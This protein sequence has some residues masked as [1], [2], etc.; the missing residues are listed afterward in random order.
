MRAKEWVSGKHLLKLVQ[1]DYSD[2]MTSIA[3]VVAAI[4]PALALGLEQKAETDGYSSY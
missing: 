3:T 2:S 4:P 1:Y